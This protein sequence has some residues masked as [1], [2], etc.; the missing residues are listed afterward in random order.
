MYGT[1]IVMVSLE[2]KQGCI[3]TLAPKISITSSLMLN[4]IS[5]RFTSQFPHNIQ[6]IS[7]L[8]P[9]KFRKLNIKFILVDEQ[10]HN[11][12]MTLTTMS[13]CIFGFFFPL[14]VT[15]EARTFPFYILDVNLNCIGYLRM[16]S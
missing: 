15:H 14:E 8:N 5:K 16:V 6:N 12:K 13:N 11:A 7:R 9:L 10:L 2:N 1:E 4:R 3:L